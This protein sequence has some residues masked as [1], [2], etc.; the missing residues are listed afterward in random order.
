MLSNSLLHVDEEYFS[1]ML[2]NKVLWFRLRKIKNLE[3]WLQ[4]FG[5]N[6]GEKKNLSKWNQ[7]KQIKSILLRAM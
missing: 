5:N 3:I 4:G 7:P 2:F 1:W 6:S